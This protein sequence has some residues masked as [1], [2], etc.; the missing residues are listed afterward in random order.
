MSRCATWLDNGECGPKNRC[1]C[2]S[3]VRN[4]TMRGSEDARRRIFL[5]FGAG[6]PFA[7][8]NSNCP[9]VPK[10]FPMINAKVL[11]HVGI[12]VESIAKHRD[13]YES[14]LGARFE[15]IEDVPSQKVKVAF[16]QVGDIRL[17]LLE[18]TDPTS[19]VAKFI[20]K[21]GEGLHHLAF[22]VDDIRTRLAELESAGVELIDKAPR[23]GAHHMQIAFLHPKSSAG[24]LTEMCEPAK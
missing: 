18:P 4:G 20:A 7:L 1:D 9:C 8:A 5:A 14:T 24:V 3:S 12:A 19:P 23:A 16:F 22:T 11:N 13:Y 6:A 10:G 21:R 2:I 15:T 17:E